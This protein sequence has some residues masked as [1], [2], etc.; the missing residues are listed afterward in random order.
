MR[1][2]GNFDT[3][4]EYYNIDTNKFC[5]FIN[6]QKTIGI[7]KIIEG[8]MTGLLVE[9]NNLYFLYGKEKFLVTESHK[10]LLEGKS[11]VENKFSLIDGNDV[12]VRFLYSTPDPKLNV[13]PFEYIDE[14]DFKWGDFI[15]KII[16]DR[17]RKRNF[18]MNLMG[19]K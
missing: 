7:Y 9:D 4:N 12:L 18:V 14:E 13:S 19:S 10:V 8:V 17:K 3:F 11:N 16:N 1:L 6:L 15:G 2:L 5:S